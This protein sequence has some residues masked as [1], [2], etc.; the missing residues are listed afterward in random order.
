[1]LNRTSAVA[2]VIPYQIFLLP[3]KSDFH[4]PV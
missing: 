4:H 3:R 1:L 2:S